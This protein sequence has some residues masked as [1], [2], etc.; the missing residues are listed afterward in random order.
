MLTLPMERE[1]EG[2]AN[3]VTGI[4]L[5]LVERTITFDVEGEAAVSLRLASYG[6]TLESPAMS[7]TTP[8]EVVDEA[9]K[10]VTL[11]GRLVNAPRSGRPD[12]SG[13]PTAYAR[14][15]AHIEGEDQA[16][17]YVCTFHR[18]TAPIALRL[19]KEDQLTVEGY[20]HPS[21]GARRLDTF[22]VVNL[23]RYP[24]MPEPQ[25]RS[26]GSAR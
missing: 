22:S 9:Q 3:L 4:H 14:F 6:L 24:G 11:S 1:Q 2:P 23:V 12:R 18:H 20:P 21:S 8:A 17:D 5:N 13:N 26:Q 19:R 10:T 15:A 16:H 7:A 25:P